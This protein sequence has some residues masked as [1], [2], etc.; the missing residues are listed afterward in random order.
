MIVALVALSF[1][2]A[3]LQMGAGEFAP[4]WPSFG[5]AAVLI[6]ARRGAAGRFRWVALV[7]GLPSGAFLQGA[8]CA[9]PAILLLVG[10]LARVTR[11][12]FSMEG[13]RPLW[14]LG[15]THAFLE[16]FLRAAA[17][18]DGM[19]SGVQCWLQALI[20]IALT[21]AAFALSDRMLDRWPRAR[22]ALERP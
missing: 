6:A 12:F 20:S 10:G 14:V 16:Q 7:A 13:F 4:I 18:S 9:A 15:C 19:P 1:L 17:S 8:L 11:K 21:G 3:V 5:L 22:H 2:T